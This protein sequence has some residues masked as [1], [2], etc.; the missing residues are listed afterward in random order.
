M[1]N[2]L[3]SIG[4]A[5]HRTLK[6]LVFLA[7]A[8][9]LGDADLALL[10]V[11]ND[12]TNGNLADSLEILHLY[13]RVRGPQR[14]LG[15]S[16]LFRPKL[17]LLDDRPWSP[18]TA[19]DTAPTLDSFLRHDSMRAADADLASLYEFLYEP[20]KR[21][22]PV[23]EGF[24]GRPSIGAAV[25][26]A[27]A[28]GGD[29]IGAGADSLQRVREEL[30]TGTAQGRHVRLF[31]VGS[32]FGGTGAA[33][34]PTIPSSL[35]AGMRQGADHVLSG[36]AFLLPYFEF[37]T[38]GLEQQ[39]PHANPDD[40]IM[41]MKDALPYYALNPS[42]YQCV[43]AIGADK[44][45]H[46][47]KAAVGKAE[48]KNP[49]DLV[50][51]L[52]A[53]AASNFLVTW[54]P[55]AASSNGHGPELFVLHREK[56]A[57]FTWT[58]VPEHDRIKPKLAAF[59]RFCFLFLNDYE[60]ELRKAANGH[61][62]ATWYGTQIQPAGVNPKS[63]EFQNQVRDLANFCGAFLRWWADLHEGAGLN[64]DLVHTSALR[65]W[66]FTDAAFPVLI[67]GERYAQNAAQVIK[68]VAG[69]PFERDPNLSGLGHF[70]RALA[71]AST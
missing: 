31:S 66:P 45:R 6:P 64:V 3:L 4:G 33:G 11:D 22:L 37:N 36:G 26:R 2:C 27:A 52:G 20:A 28:Q 49:A 68:K 8:G 18:L 46:V 13:N 41:M 29:L 10:C 25:Y 65:Q 12:S 15:D 38:G 63:A 40:F 48:Q 35:I 5:G 50:E 53:L 24:R 71:S 67:T 14:W 34:L 60:P 32:V 17:Q 70:V 51:F 7:A 30:E 62:K 19:Q 42:R 43:Y 44:W 56:E 47:P 21:N 1:S 61:L 9:A 69:M 54:N 59:T 39:G 58:D 55:P 23:T 57:V 16:A